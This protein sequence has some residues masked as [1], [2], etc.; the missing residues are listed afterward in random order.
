[1]STESAVQ[2]SSRYDIAAGVLDKIFGPSWRDKTR[3]TGMKSVDDF[4]RITVEH[5]YAD[6]WARD[7]LDY[8]TR[9]VSCLS[10]TATLGTM[11]EFKLHVEAA[12]ANGW[13]HEE[14]FEILLHLVPYIGVP[15]AVQALRAAG[16]VFTEMFTKAA[17]DQ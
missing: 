3:V 5:C 4:Q 9:S 15:K 11:E 1:M 6:A 2:E 7:T 16:D 13:S 17:A 10:V 12:L 8:K 14:I